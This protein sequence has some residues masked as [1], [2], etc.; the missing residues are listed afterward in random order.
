MQ[1]LSNR[2]HQP[3]V[4]WNIG[5]KKVQLVLINQKRKVSAFIK[6]KWECE[7]LE[8]MSKRKQ[9]RDKH[10]E[11]LLTNINFAKC[12]EEQKTADKER[13]KHKKKEQLHKVED[14]N[15]LF[16][17]FFGPKNV[18]GPIA[19]AYRKKYYTEYMPIG[20]G[21]FLRG[22]KI[23]RKE[24]LYESGA[25]SNGVPVMLFHIR[26]PQLGCNLMFAEGKVLP[27]NVNYFE[28]WYRRLPIHKMFLEGKESEI[29][30]LAP[31]NLQPDFP[32]VY[33]DWNV[34]CEIS[35]DNNEDEDEECSR[36][37]KVKWDTDRYNY[38]DEDTGDDYLERR[39]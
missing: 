24:N 8:R 32:F 19:D 3:M 18:W 38:L 35:E 25:L 12:T 4:E 14:I 2:Y 31:D 16:E 23:V 26:E 33:L 37:K 9:S 30:Y 36:N 27:S 39:T 5:Q 10:N 1:D 21:R 29:H 11:R 28:K 13:R 6:E 34:D 22:H 17:N 7:R 20:E 15:I